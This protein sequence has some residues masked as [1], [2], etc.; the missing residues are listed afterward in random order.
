MIAQRGRFVTGLVVGLLAGLT[1]ALAVALYI[2]KAPVPFINKVP[3]RSRS[4]E[5]RVGKEC[6]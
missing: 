5:R 6:W 2:T 4:E 3:Q 1:V